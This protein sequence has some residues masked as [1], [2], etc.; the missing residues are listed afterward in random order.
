MKKVG[1]LHSVKLLKESWQKISIDIIE[2]LPKSKELDTIVVIVD[3]FIEMIRLRVTITTVS[4]GEI[5][6]IYRNRIWK[7]HR[8]L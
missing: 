2:L 1:E 5:A 6:K 8:V 3:Q 4:L 7:L